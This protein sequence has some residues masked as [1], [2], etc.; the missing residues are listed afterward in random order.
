MFGLFIFVFIIFGVLVGGAFALLG[1]ANKRQHARLDRPLQ[2]VNAVNEKRSTVTTGHV[3]DL[4]RIDSCIDGIV[5]VGGRSYYL[6]RLVGTNFS[7]IS[8]NEQDARE[9]AIVGIMSTV[10]HPVTFISNTVVSDMDI[11]IDRVNNFIG[12]LNPEAPYTASLTAYATMYTN[13]LEEMRRSRKV[14]SNQTWIVLEYAG[15]D[16]HVQT[17]KERMSLLQ[18][19]FRSTVGIILEPVVNEISVLDVIH[20]ILLP[21]RTVKPSD[22]I[23]AG[24]GE[25]V[26][27]HW[28]EEA[29]YRPKEA[30]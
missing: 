26:H 15:S 6:A 27:Y 1:W 29:K 11:A 3:R 19:S 18:E 12:N 20:E 16:D 14:L 2:P 5:R 24:A 7:V 17:L 23:E 10:D 30:V 8:E 13:V 9:Q 25:P 4:L 21:E 22:Q 28:A